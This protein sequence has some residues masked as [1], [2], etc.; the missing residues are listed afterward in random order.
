MLQ[1]GTRTGGAKGSQEGEEY[2]D[3][4]RARTLDTVGEGVRREGGEAG[5]RGREGQR[6]G[7]RTGQMQVGRE[8]KCSKETD[9]GLISRN[10]R[11]AGCARTPV[12]SSILP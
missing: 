6:A 10:V 4:E 7:T 2:R 5:A 11:S 9:D 1:G 8:V 12:A 3:T